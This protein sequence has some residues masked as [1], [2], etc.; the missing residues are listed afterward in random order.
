MNSA[1]ISVGKEVL[2]HSEAESEPLHAFN[3]H[4]DDATCAVFNHNAHVFAS[5]GTDGLVNLYHVDKKLMMMTLA[6]E[7]ATVS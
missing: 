1:F 3:L 4:K 5:G 6:E 2:I 7:D